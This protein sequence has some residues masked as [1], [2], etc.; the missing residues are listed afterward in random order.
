MKNFILTFALALA[1]VTASAQTTFTNGVKGSALT[2]ATT[3]LSGLESVYLIQS[4]AS[5]TATVSQV[6][7]AATAQENAT[8]NGLAALI[9]TNTARATLITNGLAALIATNGLN[10]VATSNTLQS[11]IAANTTR[12][13]VTSNY[14]NLVTTTNA[15]A[16]AA[17]LAANLATSNA[18]LGIANAAAAQATA[19]GVTNGGN[20]NFGNLN[21]TPLIIGNVP[22]TYFLNLS[23]ASFQSITYTNTSGNSNLQ[24]TNWSAGQSVTVFVKNQTGSPQTY[25]LPNYFQ[26]NVFNLTANANTI[27]SIPN[28]RVIVFNFVVLSA[29][30]VYMSYANGY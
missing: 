28:G 24:L 7:A 16:A 21:F 8:T 18:I 23:N 14:F 25:G 15:N 26:T 29:S 13:N 20:A 30:Q 22:A 11:S 1:A 9:A 10:D 17:A 5:K 2:A 27:N 6:I 3:P 4:G 19:T 12:D